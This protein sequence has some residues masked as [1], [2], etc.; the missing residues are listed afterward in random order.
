MVDTKG[1]IDILTRGQNVLNQTSQN[2]DI[3]REY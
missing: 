2:E 1:T 3:S